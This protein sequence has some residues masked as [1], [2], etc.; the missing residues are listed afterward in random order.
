MLKVGGFQGQIG[1]WSIKVIVISKRYLTLPFPPYGVCDPSGIKSFRKEFLNKPLHKLKIK[2][3]NE[4]WKWQ[5]FK[6]LKV[7]SV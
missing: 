6:Y 4:V 3:F 1:R 2:K 5:N 7:G